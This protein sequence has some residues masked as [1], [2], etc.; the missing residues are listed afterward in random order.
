VLQLSAVECGAASLAMILGFHGRKTQIGECR[1][2]IGVGR[3]GI[4]AR[5]IANVARTYGLRVKAYSLEPTD[6]KY[7]QLPA[8]AHWDFNHFVVVERWSPRWAEIVD[9]AVGRR[10]LT[11]AAFEQS[12]TGVVLTFEPGAQFERRSAP[13]SVWRHYLT[14]LAL[15]P[16]VVAQIFGASLLLQVVGL[17]LPVATKVLID[18]VLPFQ[19]TTIMPILGIGMGILFLVHV[20]TSYLRAALLIYLQAR[21]DTRLTLGFFEHLLTLPFRFFEQ[22][23][24]GD[25]LMRLGS[26]TFIRETLT[27]QMLSVVLDGTLVLGYLALLLVQSLSFGILVLV[28]GLLQVALFLGTTRR[29]RELTQRDLLAQ[30]ESQSYLVEVL[31]GIAALKAT[32]AEERA[33]DHWS[34]RFFK[35]LNITLRRS[36]LSAVI[37]TAM[38][39][40]RTFSPLALLWAGGLW[41]LDGTLSLGTML[42]LNALAMA[43]LAPLASLVSN[44]QRLQLVGAHLDRLADVLEAVPEQNPQMVQPAPQLSGRIELNHVSFRYDPNAPLVLRDISLAVEPGQTV[45]LVGRTGSGKSTLAKLL[46]GLYTPTEG[47]LCYDGHPLHLLNYRMLRSQFGV[48]LQE[49]F[50]FSGSIRQN[51]AFNDSGLALEQVIAAARLA[52]IHDEI[53]QLPMGY[54]TLVA[55]GGG[56]SGGQRQRLVLARALAHRPAILVLDEATSQL[57]VVTERRVDEGIRQ[58]ACTRIIIAHRLSTIRNADLILVLDQGAIVER[59]S[60]N[61]LLARG[62]HYAVL[63][64]HQVEADVL[65]PMLADRNAFIPYSGSSA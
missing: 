32:G 49:P 38:T 30:A 55:E 12:L 64:Q 18:Q 13:R 57:D 43:F 29:V 51:I 15:L 60:H 33:L 46:L 25:L 26:N 62:G 27:S 61:E 23:S 11:A 50:L 45:A 1:E 53:A 63:V 5:T 24:S 34:N 47:E 41:V 58:L 36:Q 22:R 48:V 65:L 3:D 2:C 16:G 20:V 14:Y 44:G 28:V 54:E 6:F 42:A 35:H 9:P 17:A 19:I 56:L 4:S 8:I 7:L 37:D 39:A 52:A 31:S 59:G 40:L 21:I 10:R